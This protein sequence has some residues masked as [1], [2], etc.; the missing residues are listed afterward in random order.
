[1]K[2]GTIEKRDGTHDRKARRHARSKSATA[3]TSCATSA[4]FRIRCERVWA[5]LT[6]PAQLAQWLAATDLELVEAG[7]VQRTWL[8]SDSVARGT[9]TALD[10]PRLLEADTDADGRLRWE[11]ADDGD[12][13]RLTFTCTLSASEEEVAKAFAGWHIHLEHLADALDGRPV[14]WPRWRDEHLATWETY[15]DRYASLVPA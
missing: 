1:M 14:D 6:E 7:R 15:H 13:T 2:D 8:N 4:G 12:G 11:L 3:R 10:A 5:A 9:V